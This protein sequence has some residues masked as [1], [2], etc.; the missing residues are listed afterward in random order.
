MGWSARMSPDFDAVICPTSMGQSACTSATLCNT[1]QRPRSGCSTVGNDCSAS[2]PSASCELPLIHTWHHNSQFGVE[3]VVPTSNRHEMSRDLR[4]S[5]SLACGKAGGNSPRTRNSA[6]LTGEPGQVI[7]LSAQQ[8]V[9]GQ[10]SKVFAWHHQIPHAAFA[11]PR[12]SFR[13]WAKCCCDTC[14]LLPREKEELSDP[15]FLVQVR[16]LSA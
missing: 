2:T 10:S 11:T 9:G 6:D 13:G 7:G 14:L 4:A 8:N 1:W 16:L 3:L 12:Y 15:P 5:Q